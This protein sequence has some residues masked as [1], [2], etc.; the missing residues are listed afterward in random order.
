MA[1]P[2]R[3]TNDPAL[4]ARRA[5]NRAKQARY[6]ASPIR[7]ERQRD[8]RRK[9]LGIPAPRSWAF[10]RNFLRPLVCLAPSPERDRI[11]ARILRAY[12]PPRQSQVV[13]FVIE[14]DPSLT[15]AANSMGVAG[16]TASLYLNGSKRWGHRGAA[17]ALRA[18]LG[19]EHSSDPDIE[20]LLSGYREHMIKAANLSRAEYILGVVKT[21]R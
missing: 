1:P 15:C 9:R 4:A 6:N 2:I 10:W 20:F 17:H 5:Y 14:V 13:R 7:R 18:T 12:L 16:S 3:Q 11:L 19:G 8:L 21:C